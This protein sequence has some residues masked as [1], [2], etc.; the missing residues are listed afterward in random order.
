MQR[1]IH[2]D[3]EAFV[4]RILAVGTT[5]DR[6]GEARD[7]S[8]H[9]RAVQNMQR[10]VDRSTLQSRSLP[11]LRSAPQPSATWAPLGLETLLVPGDLLRLSS[12]PALL[13]RP[14]KAKEESFPEPTESLAEKPSTDVTGGPSTVMEGHEPE[15]GEPQSPD[16]EN[17]AS[18]GS[19]RAQLGD[20]LPPGDAG[21]PDPLS[22]S[23]VVQEDMSPDQGALLQFESPKAQN[24]DPLWSMDYSSETTERRQ[25]LSAD[26]GDSSS[27]KEATLPAHSGGLAS[28]P[29]EKPLES[30]LSN[31]FRS[32]SAFQN[33]NFATQ[34]ASTSEVGYSA[35]WDEFSMSGSSAPS[36]SMSAAGTSP[37]GRRRPR[38]ERNADPQE[39]SFFNN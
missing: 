34:G 14:A 8:R 37:G 35:D 38:R 4:K 2:E 30:P 11:A 13:D 26:Q 28:I 32:E 5:F 12:S 25:W 23:T 24:G 3:N 17:F 31:T 20:S 6:R 39:D 19:S 36:P 33:D 18:P 9:K 1:V 27:T 22:P 15:E 10:F 16:T 29:S 7:F 21:E